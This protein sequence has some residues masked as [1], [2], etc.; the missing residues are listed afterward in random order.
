[1]HVEYVN[2]RVAVLVRILELVHAGL[3]DGTVMTKR[4]TLPLYDDNKKLT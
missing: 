1:M 4:S 3:V 2:G